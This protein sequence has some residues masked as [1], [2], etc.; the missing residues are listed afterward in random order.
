MTEINIPAVKVMKDGRITID[1]AIRDT[2]G[3]KEGS[4]WKIT[5][6]SMEE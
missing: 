5:L 3:I 4:V 2:Y 6:E 1:K